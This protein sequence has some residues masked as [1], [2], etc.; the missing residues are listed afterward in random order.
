MYIEKYVELIGAIMKDK[1]LSEEE[2]K[3]RSD[4]IDTLFDDISDYG[5]MIITQ[6]SDPERGLSRE[7]YHRRLD[8]GIVSLRKFNKI[9]KE[10][11]GELFSEEVNEKKYKHMYDISIEISNELLKEAVRI[12]SERARENGWEGN[13]E[14]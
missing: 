5:D 7:E 8:D 9:Y 3:T 11:F 14:H 12:M 1:S 10:Y 6:K 2:I 13:I 4:E